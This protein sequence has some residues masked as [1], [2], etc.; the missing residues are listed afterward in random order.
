MRIRVIMR[1]GFYLDMKDWT[2]VKNLMNEILK[3]GERAKKIPGPTGAY[4]DKSS[5]G[6]EE[7][8]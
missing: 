1:S 5:E 2:E 6:S 8:N 7:A 3:I 4:A